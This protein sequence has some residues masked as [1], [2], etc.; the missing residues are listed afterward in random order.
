VYG[1][2]WESGTY[3]SRRY[4]IAFFKGENIELGWLAHSEAWLPDVF[5]GVCDGD[6]FGGNSPDLCVN[7]LTRHDL[8]EDQARAV[9]VPKWW[10]TD[11]FSEAN[12]PAD[13]AVGSYVTSENGFPYRFRGVG[14]LSRE[15]GGYRN[16]TALAGT[17]LFAVEQT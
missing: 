14:R 5:I 6:A 16:W 9:A 13:F 1:L 17:W 2:Q 4:V 10:V 3:E 11:H 12:V 15:W 7:R 8:S